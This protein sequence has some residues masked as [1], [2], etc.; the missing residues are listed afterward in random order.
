MIDSVTSNKNKLESGDPSDDT[1]HGSIIK[2]RAYPQSI[3]IS[4]FKNPMNS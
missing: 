2:E 3:E 1:T 4:G